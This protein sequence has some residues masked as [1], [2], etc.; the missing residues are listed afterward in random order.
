MNA[1]VNSLY[2]EYLEHTGGDKA[3]AASLALAAV[4]VENGGTTPPLTGTTPPLTALTVAQ[5]AKRLAVTQKTIYGMCQDG[6][7]RSFRVGRAVRVPAEE[8]ARMEN[9]IAA[10]GPAKRFPEVFKRHF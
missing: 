8:I 6:R 3:A 1:A 2:A 7:L 9:E 4:L 10:K 5:A